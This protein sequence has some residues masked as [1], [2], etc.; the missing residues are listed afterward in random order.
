MTQPSLNRNR[1]ILV[2]IL[3]LAFALRVAYLTHDRFHADEALYA[4]WALRILD[5]DPLLLD[6]PVDKPPLFLY[7]L[8]GAFRL[9]GSSEVAARW[10]NLAC[11]MIGIV[12][13]SRLFS[14]FFPAT[15]EQGKIWATLLLACSPF[16]LLFARTAF[17]DPMLNMWWLAAMLAATHRRFFWT[18]LL[19]GMALATKQNATVLIPV[20]LIV[21]IMSVPTAR[22]RRVIG[23]CA[24][25]VAGLAIPWGLVT[26]WDSARWAIRPGYW[27]QSILSY[28]GLTWTP[29][30]KWPQRFFEW[31][32]W[33]RYLVGGWGGSL[34]LLLGGLKDEYEVE[35]RLGPRPTNRWSIILWTTFILIYIL[36]HTILSF[37]TW[38]RYLL[39][40]AAP[41]AWLGGR[42]IQ[43]GSQLLRR[44]SSHVQSAFGLA[45]LLIA[46]SVGLRAAFNG[47]PVGGEHWAY[48]G[49]DQI[50]AYLQTHAAPDAVLYHHWL[51]WH[52]S[53]YLHNSTFELRWWQNGEHLRREARRTDPAREQYIVLPDWRPLD[54]TVAGIRFE[55]ILQTERLT[56]YRVIVESE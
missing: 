37:S 43:A 56:L 16:D 2:L 30:A 45:V 35:V 14:F 13:T 25:F 29:P 28:G 10:V 47:Y 7:T 52:Y 20:V 55:P 1:I 34:L 17:T 9:F 15:K 21:S 46:V 22:W 41:V 6:E 39:P 38:D 23:L 11:S 4:G 19:S 44:I 12:L 31:L 36:L 54:P 42:A 27:E 50:A 32:S 5:D 33:A 51:R 24:A 53:Y 26:W 18:G 49:I 40:M 3:L 48:Q 8:A